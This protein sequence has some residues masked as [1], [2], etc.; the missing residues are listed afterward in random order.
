MD[1]LEKASNMIKNAK[2]IVVITGAGISTAS[3]IPD[4]RGEHGVY[5]IDPGLFDTLSIR[6]LKSNPEKFY[7]YFEKMLFGINQAQPNTAHLLLA[8]WETKRGKNITVI[9]QNIDSLHKRAGS[10]EI[11]EL[12]GHARTFKYMN[13]YRRDMIPADEVVDESGRINYMQD[14]E[15]I[16]PCV[17]LFGEMLNEQDFLEAEKKI[18]NADLILVIG[19]SL[20]VYPFSGL[21]NYSDDSIPLVVIN[22]ESPPVLRDNVTFLE[23]DIVEIME[24]LNGKLG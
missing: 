16:R 1:T 7:D 19:T 6:T 23:G 17:V 20:T 24:K 22:N 13:P 9:T 15:I 8:E 11:L 18:S 2:N 14:D 4:Y 3:G 12:H 21:V 5:V 10:K